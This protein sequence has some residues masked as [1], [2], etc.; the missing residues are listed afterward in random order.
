MQGCFYLCQSTWQKL[1]ELGLAT[2]YKTNDN[3]RHFCGMLDGL[4]LLLVGDVKSGMA[5]IRQKIL[6]IPRLQELVD[7]LDATYVTGTARTINRPNANLR[8]RRI[9]PLFPPEKWNVSVATLE[10]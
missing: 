1:E 2:E 3:L 5:F 4:A 9:P 8:I 7:Y 6:D 10:G